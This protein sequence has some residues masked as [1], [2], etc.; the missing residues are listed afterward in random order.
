MGE[1]LFIF[2]AGIFSLLGGCGEDNGNTVSSSD[3]DVDGDTDADTDSDADTDTDA[4]A[5]TDTD[6]DADTDTDTDTDTDH[7]VTGIE[8]ECNGIDDD[9]NGIVDDVDIGKDGI[10]DCLNIA[11]VGIPGTWGEG[12]VFSEW[13]SERSSMEII[14]LADGIL[15]DATLEPFQVIVFLNVGEGEDGINRQYGE[16]EVAALNRWIQAGGGIMTLIGYADYPEEVDNI[17]RLLSPYGIYYDTVPILQKQGQDTVPITGWTAHP[18]TEGINAVGVDNGYEVMGLGTL[19][20]TESTLDVARVVTSGEGNIF[21]WGDE[22]ISYDSEWVEMT[23]YQVERFWLNIFKWL[24]PEDECQ[25]A[26][27]PVI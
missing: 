25:V 16:E 3:A 5:D 7:I 15:D 19:L 22:W 6:T 1:I 24:T 8:T 20:A 26:I 14:N 9:Q 2:I 21:V 10:C 4:D 13:L 11:T 27:P 12:N 23:E 18:T 17:N